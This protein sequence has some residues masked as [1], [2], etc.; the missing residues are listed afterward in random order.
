LEEGELEERVL[1]S[2]PVIVLGLVA[3]GFAVW[4]ARDVLRRDRGTPEMQDIAD[5]IFQGATAYLNRQYRT[6]AAMSL[7][8]SVLMGV[9]VALFEKDHEVARGVIT[10]VAFLF[11]ALLSGLSGFIGMYVA[12]RSNIRTAAAARRS[13]GEALTVALR[14]GAVSG[15]L[16]IALGLL[17]ILAVYSVVFGFA[18][19]ALPAVAETRSGSSALPSAPASSPSSPNSAAASTPRRPTSAPTSSARWKPASPRTTP[20]TRR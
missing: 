8:V 18:E 14:G 7:V 9:L 13:L 1:F 17:G 5:R 10:S 3:I 15:F 4:L 2:L 19:G 6:I 20:A 12:V 16:V 11:G